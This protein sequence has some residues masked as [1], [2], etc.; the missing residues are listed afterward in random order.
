VAGTGLTQCPGGAARRPHLRGQVRPL[1]LCRAANADAAD[2]Q[3]PITYVATARRSSTRSST[4]TSSTTPLLLGDVHGFQLLHSCQRGAALRFTYLARWPRGHHVH[5][6]AGNPDLPRT[7][8]DHRPQR[9]QLSTDAGYNPALHG[10]NTTVAL[11]PLATLTY[12]V[13]SDAY[14]HQQVPAPVELYHLRRPPMSM[15]WGHASSIPARSAIT[16][17]GPASSASRPSRRSRAPAVEGSPAA[18]SPAGC[19]PTTSR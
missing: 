7:A 13:P 11:A 16:S 14:A 6:I 10:G 3:T 1:R 12:I 2:R 8:H 4:N 19:S 18:S 15:R 17:G 5:G 9:L